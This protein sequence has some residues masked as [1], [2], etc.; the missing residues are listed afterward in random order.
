[1]VGFE[2]AAIPASV[3]ADKTPHPIGFDDA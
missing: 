2:I 3:P 1:V